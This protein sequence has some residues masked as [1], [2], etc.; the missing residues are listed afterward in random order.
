MTSNCKCNLC[1]E[2]VYNRELH[3]SSCKALD[4]LVVADVSSS[5]TPS[6]T[7]ITDWKEQHK[8]IHIELHK[9]LDALL[10]DFIRHT[11]KRLHDTN[12]LQFMEW[13]YQQTLN[14]TEE[15]L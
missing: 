8:K 3:N 14:P 4:K 13:S 5:Y 7:P 2:E 12:I 1:G 15:K 9:N 10:A 6:Y 11:D